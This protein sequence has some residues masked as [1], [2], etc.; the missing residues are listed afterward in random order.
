MQVATDVPYI[1]AST[2]LRRL[3]AQV[4]PL[5]RSLISQVPSGLIS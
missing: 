2:G 1:I 3:S 5:R 4:R